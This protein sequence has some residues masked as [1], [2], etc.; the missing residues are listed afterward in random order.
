M[1]DI[2]AQK[3][4]VYLE[5]Y[6]CQMNDRDSERMLALLAKQGYRETKE[7]GSAGLIVINTCSIRQ[8]A[9]QKV[10][11]RL[12]RLRSWKQEDKTRL[13]AVAGCM[14]QQEGERFLR[15]VRHVDLVL[16]PGE[17]FRLPELLKEV[18]EIRRPLVATDLD[19]N[20]GRWQDQ[21]QPEHS[22]QVT[23]LVTVME[24]C[25]NYCSYCIVPYVRGRERSRPANEIVDEVERLVAEG[26]R[27]VTL[28]G[29]NVNSY[30]KKNGAGTNFAQLLD[31]IE[32]LAGLERIRFITSHPR[33]LFPDLTERFRPGGKLCEH[34]HLPVQS[35]STRV[36]KLMGRGYTREEYLEKVARLKSICPD[37]AIT[38]DI[39]VGFPGE[40]EEDFEQTLSLMEE[41]KFDNSFS[42]KFSP[43]PGTRAT[44]MP[45]DV[46][47]ELKTERLIRLQRLQRDLAEKKNRGLEGRIRYILVEGPSKK[48]ADELCGRTRCNRVVN[49]VGPSTLIGKLVKLRI[50]TGLPNSLRASVI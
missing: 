25:D 24:G 1:K 14:A 41:V 28:I 12:G 35:G 17:L 13:L 23:A 42:F 30:G 50:E 27:E 9:E 18:E 29:Q 44:K 43:R 39:I 32:Q 46:A 5:T 4:L 26:V 45:D 16:G 22:G 15:R 37:I 38:T 36:L 31:R 49:F 20:E 21:L 48:K 34:I 47:A 10:Y 40:S 7:V 2:D 8:K 3:K 33:D 19:K 6:G 11:S